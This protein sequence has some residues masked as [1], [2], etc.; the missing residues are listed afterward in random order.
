MESEDLP[1]T[2]PGI[3]PICE[4]RNHSRALVD[5]RQ[6][7]FVADPFQLGGGISARLLLDSRDLLAPVFGFSLDHADSS[8]LYEEHVIGRANV[9]IVF[10]DGDARAGVEID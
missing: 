10:L 2:G 6:R 8:A 5:E 4:A 3:A 7:L 1:R 9:G